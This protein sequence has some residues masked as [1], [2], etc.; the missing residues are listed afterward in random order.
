MSALAQLEV[1]LRRDHAFGDLAKTHVHRA[2]RED[3]LG[4]LIGRDALLAHWTTQARQDT[5]IIAD[6]GDMIAFQVGAGKT[7]WFGHR[8]IKREGDMIVTETLIENRGIAK[9]APPVHAPL[10]ELRAG[11]GQVDAG[12]MPILPIGFPEAARPLATILHKAWNG[13]A[14]DLYET[15]WLVSL[16]NALPDATFYFER[17]LV[18]GETIALLWRVHGHHKDGQRVRLIGSSVMVLDGERITSD[19]TVLDFDALTAQ[20]DRDVIGYG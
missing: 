9:I 4:F 19:S 16:V 10:G 11:R 15:P 14:F 2:V 12:D 20:L 7:T 18:D 8:W 17:A 1:R 5:S 6:L 3:S 13:R